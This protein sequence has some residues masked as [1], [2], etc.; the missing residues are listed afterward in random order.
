[1]A[2]RFRICS[3]RS[4]ILNPDFQDDRERLLVERLEFADLGFTRSSGTAD[5]PVPSQNLNPDI[6]MMEPAEDWYR[7]DSA[8]ILSRPKIRSIF[9]QREMGSDFVVIL[10][11]DL[12]HAAQ[13]RFAE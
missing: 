1:M 8:D 11:V 3:T 7:C 5:R 12:Q 10:S 2:R 9:I 4:S 13:V 6:L